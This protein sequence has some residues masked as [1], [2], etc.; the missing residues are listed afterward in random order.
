M[1]CGL[2]STDT[3]TASHCLIHYPSHRPSYYLSQ[4][5]AAVRP[6]FCYMWVVSR[7]MPPPLQRLRHAPPPES[8]HAP[9]VSRVTGICGSP[10]V[11]RVT[12]VRCGGLAAGGV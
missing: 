2:D 3:E 6:S 11:S 9:R 12:R 10:R 4:Q 7:C 5:A 1:P 8:L